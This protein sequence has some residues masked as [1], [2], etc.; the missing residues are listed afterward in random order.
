MKTERRH[1]L[2]HNSLDAELVKIL[3]YLKAHGKGISLA[4]LTAVAVISVGWIVIRN[5][6]ASV[7]VPRQQYDQL[8]SIDISTAQGRSDAL[9]GFEELAAQS[10]NAKFAALGS[11][12]AGDICLIQH[13][14]GDH[15]DGALAVAK[16]HYQRV[17]DEFSDN[18]VALGRAYLGLAKLAEDQNDLAL[19]RENYQQVISLGDKTSEMA[20]A[21]A[22]KAIAML[23]D[24]K[25]PV[26]LALKRPDPPATQPDTAVEPTTKPA[27]KIPAPV[28]PTT[29]PAEPTTQ[30]APA[31]IQPEPDINVTP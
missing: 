6:A 23:D 21:A 20:V 3:D 4:I 26:R 19:A 5:R 30:P 31:I 18:T 27:A 15:A 12:E 13:V 24:L 11:V 7:S 28:A 22:T 29:K 1:E 17:V 16:K 9:A 10:G 2:K 8:K 25:E 14:S